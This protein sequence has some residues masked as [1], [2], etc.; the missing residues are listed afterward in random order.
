MTWLSLKRND[1]D[2]FCRLINP[3]LLPSLLEAV[4]R[5]EKSAEIQFFMAGIFLPSVRN[6]L[7]ALSATN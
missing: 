2:D 5:G 7:C 4:F 1:Y 3:P 6:S